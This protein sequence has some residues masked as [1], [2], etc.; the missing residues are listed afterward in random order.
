[1]LASK[2]FA[3]T[4]FVTPTGQAGGEYYVDSTGNRFFVCKFTSTTDHSFTI[5]HH[6][7]IDYLVI[8]GG[9]GGGHG[10]GSGGGGAGGF[11][12]GTGFRLDAGVYTISVGAG[13]I[14]SSQSATQSVSGA[15]SSI[16]RSSDST[17]MLRAFGGGFG[18]N[19]NNSLNGGANGGS[20]G[21]ARGHDVSGG[22]AGSGSD[23]NVIVF[24]VADPSALHY[25]NNGGASGGHLYHGGGGG[26]AGAAGAT[27]GPTGTGGD[28]GD[29]KNEIMGLSAANSTILLALSSINAGV[30]DSGTRYLAGGG[31]GMRQSGSGGGAFN[32]SAGGAGGKGGGATGGWKGSGSG[33]QG[34]A[35]APTANTGSGGGA[36]HS[37]YGI[38]TGGASG[39]IIL[40]FRLN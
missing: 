16:T 10:S 35:T 34:A 26:G 32:G 28:G 23:A 14:A 40:R 11:L 6:T 20:G 29:G 36:S 12:T 2:G 18:G 17:V 38:A 22:I 3:D 27:G 7:I 37:A 24:G 9:G 21:G 31:G 25:G 1:M 15:N 19:E 30:V 33:N 13:G 4:G 39:I 5:R 8:A